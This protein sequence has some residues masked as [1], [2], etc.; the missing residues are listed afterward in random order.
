MVEEEVVAVLHELLWS[1]RSLA[2]PP[3]DELGVVCRE[4]AGAGSG[5]GGLPCATSSLRRLC[6]LLGHLST[7]STARHGLPADHR[8][9]SVRRANPRTTPFYD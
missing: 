5:S 3:R 9:N 1:A 2:A 4:G 6:R 7:T 8:Y